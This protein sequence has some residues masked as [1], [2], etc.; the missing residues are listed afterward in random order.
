MR[1]V[2]YSL[3]SVGLLVL[4]ASA[5]GSIIVSI[6]ATGNPWLAG[7][8]D[9][10]TSGTTYPIPYDSAPANS[11]AQYPATINGGDVFTFI[12]TGA[13]SHGSTLQGAP[14]TGPAGA[15]VPDGYGLEIV[16]RMSPN[17]NGSENGIADITAP[18]DALIGVFLNNNEPSLSAPPPPLD[19][20]TSASRNFTTISPELS[21]PFFIGTGEDSADILQQFVAPAGATRLFFGMMDQYNWSDNVGSFQITATDVT[22]ISGSLPEPGSLALLSIGALGLIRRRR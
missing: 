11:P 22:A 2:H 15:Q 8:P 17:S 21:Q 13:V 7:M 3:I 19:F 4:S 10:S 16:S 18:I 5:Y 6:P 20:T 12:A 14:L 9:G 1:G